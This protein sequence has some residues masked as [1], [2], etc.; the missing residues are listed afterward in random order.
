M[1]FRSVVIAG[2]HQHRDARLAQRHRVEVHHHA[3][4]RGG[5]NLEGGAGEAAAGNP[6]PT[7]QAQVLP[8]LELPAPTVPASATWPTKRSPLA[9]ALALVAGGIAMGAALL[10][11][12]SSIAPVVQTAGASVYNA[13]T[14]ER[15]R[16]LAAAGD[17]AVCHTAPGGTPNTGGRAMETPFGKVY[18]TNLTP[19]A[20]TGIGQWSFSA[21]QR[22]MREGISRDGHRLYPAFPYT[23]FAQV[24]DDELLAVLRRSDATCPRASRPD[25]PR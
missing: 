25:Q 12:R 4:A 21:F 2:D 24:G 18:T 20:E 11:W 5:S 13:A 22:A 9:R 7:E 6:P 8:T 16:L 3:D 17:C 10:G 1:L 14:I 23:A 15:G 19:D